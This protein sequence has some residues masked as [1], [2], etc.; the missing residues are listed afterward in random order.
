M[1][2]ARFSTPRVAC[3]SIRSVH[4]RLGI[5][6]EGYGPT[7]KFICDRSGFCRLAYPL[8]ANPRAVLFG[9]RMLWRYVSID[10]LLDTNFCR[11][12]LGFGYV[13]LLRGLVPRAL[14][15]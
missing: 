13:P 15:I 3:A 9:R 1:A 7:A 6:V 2:R 14:F 4:R 11:C 12:R 5:P 10:R 8:S